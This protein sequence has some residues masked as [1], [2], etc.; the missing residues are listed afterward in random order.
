MK[1]SLRSLILGGVLLA[2]STFLTGQGLSEEPQFPEK[3]W[4]HGMHFL[5]TAGH[6]FNDDPEIGFGMEYVASR[7][8]SPFFRAGIGGGLNLIGMAETRRFAPVF[9]ELR[10]SPF[11][12]AKRQ[13]FFLVDGGYA[14][15]WKDEDS[16]N[17]S[18]KGGLRLHAALGMKWQVMRG[19][20]IFTDFGYI[21]QE[22]QTQ[23]NNFWW[24]TQ[25]QDEN[26]IEETSTINRWMLRLGFGF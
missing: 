2:S 1:P 22:S 24:W 13:P 20:I 11:P 26:Y 5:S 19:G 3:K 4:M 8:I 21:R 12:R 9:G 10:F 17:R 25:N 14:W 23:R 15:A 16:I 7:K 6:T 18:V